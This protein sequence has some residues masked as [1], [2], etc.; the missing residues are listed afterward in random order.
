[1]IINEQQLKKAVFEELK[2]GKE[3]TVEWNCGGD[4]AILSVHWE[5][6]EI[7]YGDAFAEDIDIYL[8]IK[9]NLP[10]AGE[11]SMEG[12]GKLIAENDDV[13]LVYESRLKGYE[14]F[15]EEYNYLGWKEVDELDKDNSGKIVLFDE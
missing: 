11:F 2:K 6:E 7:S 14:D 5:E 15:D 3:I 1:M 9:L 12:G 4:E 13:F 8:S 10:D